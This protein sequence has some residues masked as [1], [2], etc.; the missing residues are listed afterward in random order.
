LSRDGF[1]GLSILVLPL[2]LLAALAYAGGLAA[3]AE[4]ARYQPPSPP[5]L[6]ADAVYVVDVTSGTELYAANADE[7]LPPASLTKIVSALVVLAEA[8][9]DARV[10]IVADDLVAPEESQVGL[11]AGDTLRVRDLFTG[12]LVPSGNDATLALA[13]HLGQQALGAETTPDAA[14]E[15]FVKQMNETAAS[16]GATG[17]HFA[18]ATGIDA[19][20]HVMTARDVAILTE[21][22][23]ALPLFA[24]T[25]AMT[26]AVLPSESRPDGYAVATT[27]QLLQE[28]LVNGVKTGT[29]PKAGGCLA[30][31]FAVG[32]NDVIAVVLGSDLAETAEGLQDNSARYLDTRALLDAVT[33]DY[34]WLDPAAPG[35][36]DGLA[37]ELRVW[38]VTLAAEAL[39]PV[40]A[41]L[42]TEVEYRLVLGPPAAPQTPVGEILFLVGDRLLAERPAV[43]AG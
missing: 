22:A 8:D 6:S 35:E 29:T 25:V 38:D 12:M 19:A 1:H 34:V 17:S 9:F 23:L 15:W 18:N 3:A 43:Q 40:P 10:E 36:L 20:G 42:A 7:P 41:E 16:L 2:V 27:N 11:V 21:A 30:T 28:G 32:P 37:D 14:V 39:Q 13:R 4:V 31:S 33:R 24:E 5:P 26:S